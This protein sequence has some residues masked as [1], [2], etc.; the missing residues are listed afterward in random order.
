M[1]FAP[2]KP[3]S[4]NAVAIANDECEYLITYPFDVESENQFDAAV[5]GSDNAGQ[6]DR[7]DQSEQLNDLV[8]EEAKRGKPCREKHN[9]NK[10][11]EF[12]SHVL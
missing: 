4:I 1:A 11:I 3:R 8:G 7:G 10:V 12:P 9:I 5:L 2:P 6:A